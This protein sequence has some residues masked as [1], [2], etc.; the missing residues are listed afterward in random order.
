MERQKELKHGIYAEETQNGI[1]AKLQYF[2][3]DTSNTL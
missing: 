1:V 2:L 3:K